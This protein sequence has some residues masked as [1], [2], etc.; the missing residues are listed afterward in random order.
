[1][2]KTSVETL[3]AV[4]APC[5]ANVTARLNYLDKIFDMYTTRISPQASS[6][7]LAL[8]FNY[9]LMVSNVIKALVLK[10]R[11]KERRLRH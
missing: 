6:I 1:M 8:D 4:V 2:C 5:A 11:S 10:T 7:V 3:K 9:N